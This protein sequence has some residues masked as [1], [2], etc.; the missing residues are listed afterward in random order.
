MFSNSP[1]ELGVR[2]FGPTSTTT[3]GKIDAAAHDCY[4]YVVVYRTPS[5]IAIT[6]A[7]PKV[8]VNGTGGDGGNARNPEVK[9]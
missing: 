9:Q 2:T 3:S 4:P 7:D 8:I 1:M 5:N 6:S